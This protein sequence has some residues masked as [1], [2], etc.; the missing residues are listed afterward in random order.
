MS[1]GTHKIPSHQQQHGHIHIVVKEHFQIQGEVVGRSQEAVST[2][3]EADVCSLEVVLRIQG[4]A[5]LDHAMS[6]VSHSQ[7]VEA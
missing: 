5:A 4:V 6:R 3:E 2:L 1:E 7:G